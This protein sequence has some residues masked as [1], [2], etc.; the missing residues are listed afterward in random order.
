MPA[1]SGPQSPAGFTVRDCVGQSARRRMSPAERERLGQHHHIGLVTSGLPDALFGALEVPL[2]LPGLD[3]HLR[4]GKF[5]DGV[6]TVRGGRFENTHT[7][8]AP[9]TRI[10]EGLKADLRSGSRA[11]K[12]H[13]CRAPKRKRHKQNVW[14]AFRLSSITRPPRA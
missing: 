5:H 10:I 2:I 14:Q 7:R 8:T 12:R 4:E 13:G 3:E 9:R 1:G 11:L 6:L